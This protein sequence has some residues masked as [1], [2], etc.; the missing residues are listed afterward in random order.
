MTHVINSNSQPALQK[1][2]ISISKLSNVR[3]SKDS[4]P[5]QS[6]TN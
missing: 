2:I 6:A 4:T 1:K 5:S 3:A